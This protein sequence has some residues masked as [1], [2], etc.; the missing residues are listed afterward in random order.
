MLSIVKYDFEFVI[1]L[2]PTPEHKDYRS[3]PSH[4]M[5]VLYLNPR[6]SCIPWKHFTNETTPPSPVI[7]F[8]LCFG[9]DVV[10]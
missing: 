6:A 10:R 5:F 7:D 2:P 4:R 8:R 1:F 9:E 3:V